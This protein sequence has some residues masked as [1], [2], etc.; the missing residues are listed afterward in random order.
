MGEASLGKSKSTTVDIEER[1]AEKSRKAFVLGGL[2]PKLKPVQLWL[3][4]VALTAVAGVICDTFL[5]AL[6]SRVITCWVVTYASDPFY[7][8]MIVSRFGIAY[9]KDG[10]LI[11]DIRMIR[12]HYLTT[13]FAL[14]LFTCLPLELF[15]FMPGIP[16]SDNIILRDVQW[17]Y[18]AIFRCNRLLRLYFVFSHFGKQTCF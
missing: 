13:T 16:D 2:S 17:K 18:L 5:W 3:G 14:D 11:T 15:A 7:L 4:V 8:M 9:Y 12:K 1:M 10:I 6:D